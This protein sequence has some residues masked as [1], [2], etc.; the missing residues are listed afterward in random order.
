ME[1]TRVPSA[2][3]SHIH[4]VSCFLSFVSSYLCPI[5]TFQRYLVDSASKESP[6]PSQY[7][8]VVECLE[9]YVS[10]DYV[11]I[12]QAVRLDNLWTNRKSTVRSI[13]E[14]R[15]WYLQGSIT[16]TQ[17]VLTFCEGLRERFKDM[18]PHEM[19]IPLQRPLGYVGYT[20]SAQQRFKEH[21]HGDTSWL[22]NLVLNAFRLE[23]GDPTFVY[24][25]R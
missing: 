13:L 14:G 17:A 1:P 8:R 25:S 22:H 23:Y 10:G 5:L 11:S 16:R 12:E 19:E 21:G 15:H 6:S 20:M 4:K 18:G 3:S 9:A 7:L 2:C 24:D